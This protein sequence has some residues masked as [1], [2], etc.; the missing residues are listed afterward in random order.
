[1][2]A[3]I[4]RPTRESIAASDRLAAEDRAA[5]EAQR[6]QELAAFRADGRVT[7]RVYALPTAGGVAVHMEAGANKV[8]L[9]RAMNE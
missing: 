6:Q 9:E 2:D 7:V 8:V 5:R 4:I 1:M 3:R